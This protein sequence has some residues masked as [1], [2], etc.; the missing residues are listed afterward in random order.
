MILFLFL[1]VHGIVD[2]TIQRTIRVQQE[3]SMLL[4]EK[5]HVHLTNG[6]NQLDEYVL[7]MPGSRGSHVSFIQAAEDSS[8][9]LFQIQKQKVNGSTEFKIKFPNPISPNE[10]LKFIVNMVYL[11]LVSAYPEYIEQDSKQYVL[12]KDKMAFQL[13]YPCSKFSLHV[14]LPS[15]EK[16]ISFTEGGV[17]S[18]DTVE[19]KYGSEPSIDL[20]IHF[21]AR[22]LGLKLLKLKREIWI[23]NLGKTLEVQD[24]CAMKHEGAKIDG[25]FSRLKLMQNQNK[26]SNKIMGIQIRI[27]ISASEIYFRDDV[28]NVSTST[29]FSA[30]K[31]KT[32]AIRPRFVLYGDWFYNWVHGYSC[33]GNEMME[34]ND[35]HQINIPLEDGFNG[36]LIKE[37]TIE[38]VLPEGAS[39]VTV[40]LLMDGEV[41]HIAYEFKKKYFYLDTIGRPMVSVSFPNWVS[42]NNFGQKANLKVTYSL[43][44]TSYLKPFVWT[45][46]AAVILLLNKNV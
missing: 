37:F 38:A 28:G 35:K 10:Q 3:G 4:Y 44:I 31:F 27:P 30:L 46:V 11:N 1:F 41:K 19:Y 14:G 17:H 18:G 39:D 32:L 16:P 2:Q 8:S 6:N 25:F 7:R 42:R 12:L 33:N 21:E 20:N 40:E 24:T 29:V 45:F 22:N 36:V 5:T 15:R 34:F 9:V 43:G 13:L 23:R 26:P